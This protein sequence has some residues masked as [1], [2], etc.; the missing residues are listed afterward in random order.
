[1]ELNRAAA[2][3]SMR[4]PRTSKARRKLLLLPKTTPRS[5]CSSGLMSVSES[6]AYSERVAGCSAASAEKVLPLSAAVC[7][8]SS[9]RSPPVVTARPPSICIGISLE[10]THTL[11]PSPSS[12][13]SAARTSCAAQLTDTT[14][15]CSQAPAVHSARAKRPKPSRNSVCSD[16]ALA[17]SVSGTPRNTP[18]ASTA[19]TAEL[20]NVDITS[21]NLSRR[22]GNPPSIWAASEKVRSVAAP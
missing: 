7:I 18:L 16:P 19:T 17:S 14:S 15:T 10:C 12:L 4:T 20:S 13:A 11:S 3:G 6:P 1:M 9:L 21:T 8:P 2:I 22:A 5:A